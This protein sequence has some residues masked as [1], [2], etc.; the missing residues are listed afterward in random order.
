MTVAA[1]LALVGFH[2]WACTADDPHACPCPHTPEL[3]EP[4]P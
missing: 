3:E 2:A 4:T 1:L